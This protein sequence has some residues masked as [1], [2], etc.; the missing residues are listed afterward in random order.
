MPN[1][2]MEG[3]TCLIA[4]GDSHGVHISNRECNQAFPGFYESPFGD[5]P[6]VVLIDLTIEGVYYG[7]RVHNTASRL[8]PGRY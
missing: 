6:A 8:H 5:Y 2:E 7:T 3:T 4:V 1:H